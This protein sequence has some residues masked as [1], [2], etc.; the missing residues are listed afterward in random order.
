MKVP[1][2]TGFDDF[3]RVEDQYLE[4]KANIYQRVFHNTL[5]PTLGFF[6]YVMMQEVCSIRDPYDSFVSH[7]EL[8][9]FCSI[10]IH[11]KAKTLAILQTLKQ[12]SF[13]RNLN[14]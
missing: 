2:Y 4:I 5:F 6:E 13:I 12:V 7:Y 8:C 10:Y 9:L 11:D 3:F 1:D 14:C